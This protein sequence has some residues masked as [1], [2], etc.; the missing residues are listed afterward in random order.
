MT[1][2]PGVG[3]WLVCG[4]SRGAYRKPGPPMNA[5]PDTETE[6]DATVS[7]I[8]P[9]PFPATKKSLAVRVCRAAQML[10][11]MITAKYSSPT[12]M[13]AGWAA[14][15]SATC[16]NAEIGRASV[17]CRQRFVPGYRSGL[18]S[19]VFA[20]ARPNALDVFRR[21]RQRLESH[22]ILDGQDDDRQPP[23]AVDD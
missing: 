17:I 21:Q 20:V 14:F 16:S 23:D 2:V 15:G 4:R 12:V 5:N 9:I 11:P 18:R 8:S 7:A 10:M 22:R 1:W 3:H 19:R 13:T 6:T